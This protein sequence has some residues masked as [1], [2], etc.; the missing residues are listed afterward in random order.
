MIAAVCG[1]VSALCL[2]AACKREE[3]GLRVDP[4]SSAR[5]NSKTLSELRPGNVQP[6]S[7]PNE[8][9]QNAFAMNEGKRLY[10]WYNCVGCH[11]HGG[12]GIGPP[13]MDA[14]WIYG[15]APEQ[16][17]ATIV[18]GRPNG[19]PSFRGKI[20]DYQ[21]WQLAAYVRSMSGQ[22]SKD[23]SPSRDD[24]MNVKKPEQST[25]QQEPRG[26]GGVPKSAERPQ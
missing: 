25:E 1:V 8:F 14:K 26:T 3:R 24:D 5:V 9:E 15:G 13:L 11:A 19:M 23:A 16:I 4:P 7:A 22:V 20:P 10:E 18:E 21:V 6:I 2:V 17:F 12:G